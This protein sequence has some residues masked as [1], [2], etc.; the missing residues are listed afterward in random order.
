[1]IKFKLGTILKDK[2]TDFEGTA[3]ARVVYLSGSGTTLM[4][5]K[6]AG[7]D[8]IGIEKNKE[9]CEIA[10]RRIKAIPESLF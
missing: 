8:Y 7:R 4:A 1:M 5:C 3:I 10:R 2:I 9:Y 6:E